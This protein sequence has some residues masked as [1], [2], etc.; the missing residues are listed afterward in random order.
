M[1]AVEFILVFCVWFVGGFVSG[2]SGIGGAMIAVPIAAT[3]IPMHELIPLTCITNVA[4]DGCLASMHFRQ[5]RMSALLPMLVGSIPGAFVGLFALQILSGGMLQGAVGALLLYYVYWQLTFRVKAAHTES[6]GFGSAA[7]FGSG[8]LGTAISFDGPPVGAYGLYVGW[9]PRVFL[10][11]LGVFFIIRGSLTCVL[12]AGAGLYTQ[13]VLDYS[14]Y[15][16][17]ATMLGTLCAF[18]FVRHIP[19]A[20]FRRVLLVV[21]ALAGLT[22]LWR[23][24]M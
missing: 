1:P 22:C 7:G 12:Q 20:Q 4:M 17:P 6:W 3:F 10:G 19:V 18:P 5:C 9:Q 13:A 15:G 2:I 14:L 21:I 11:T 24:L 16:V 23:A 8:L